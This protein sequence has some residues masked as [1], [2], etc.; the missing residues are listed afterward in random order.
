MLDEYLTTAEILSEAH[1]PISFRSCVSLW[2]R[3]FEKVVANWAYS[4][5]ITSPDRSL[6]GPD[7]QLRITGAFDMA[8]YMTLRWPEGLG[9]GQE[10]LAHCNTMNPNVVKASDTTLVT[11]GQP[12]RAKVRQNYLRY[13]TWS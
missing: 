1:L 7:N 10:V 13:E 2:R 5:L 11:D 6:I 3:S 12:R 8:Y 4:R 9:F